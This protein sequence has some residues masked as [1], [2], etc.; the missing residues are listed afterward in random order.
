MLG[1][2]AVDSSANTYGKR[3]KL[4]CF[5]TLSQGHGPQR[6]A[7]W[8]SWIPQT[9]QQGSGNGKDIQE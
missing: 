3:D 1:V 9:T 2:Y 5:Q 8:Q 7:G 4:Q 6:A